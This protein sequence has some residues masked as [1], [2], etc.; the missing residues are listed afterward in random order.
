MKKVLIGCGIVALICF[1]CTA[2]VVIYGGVKLA[3]LGQSFEEAGA[4]V[5][6]VNKLHPFVEPEPGTEMEPARFEDY[7][8]VRDALHARITEVEVFREL[9]ALATQTNNQTPPNIGV[10]DILGAIGEI[11]Q[12]VKDFAA[13]L[14]THEMS[15]AE[16][17]W[18]T[19]SSFQ[20]I[21]AGQELGDQELGVLWDE[22]KVTMSSA[23]RQ[24]DQQNNAELRGIDLQYEVEQAEAAIVPEQNI[25]LVK[26]HLTAFSE[27]PT[28]LVFEMV[29]LQFFQQQG[30]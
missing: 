16:Y 8:A 9:M 2:G 13:I 26:E 19:M 7:L 17:E 25:A 4:A 29:M 1:V 23:Q 28:L 6:A 15:V 11:P 24:I 10:A 27:G 20:A 30:L 21:A 14:D 5:T 3:K 22:L 12:V 18:H